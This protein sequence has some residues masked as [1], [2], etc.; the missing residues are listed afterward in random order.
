M[1]HRPRKIKVFRGFFMPKSS[2]IVYP[3]LA[4]FDVKNG[5]SKWSNSYF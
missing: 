4:F 1:V 2:G 5:V 3:N